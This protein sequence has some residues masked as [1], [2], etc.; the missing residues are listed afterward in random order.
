MANREVERSVEC[1]AAIARG[2]KQSYKH[3]EK[4]PNLLRPGAD[5]RSIFK[6]G[7]AVKKRAV[8]GCDARNVAE[9]EGDGVKQ[10]WA[11]GTIVGIEH[12][13]KARRVDEMTTLGMRS[14]PLPLEDA[15]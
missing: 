4:T 5:A 7:W 8:I 13:C 3:T 9:V 6:L 12:S 1:F 15:R 2:W 14:A 11:K 10:L